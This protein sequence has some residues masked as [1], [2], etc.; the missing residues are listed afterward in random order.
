LALLGAD[1]PSDFVLRGLVTVGTIQVRRL[2][3]LA[4]VEKFAFFHTIGFWLAG[5]PAT[6]TLSE[7]A[8]NPQPNKNYCT[9]ARV[10]GQL[11]RGVVS[12]LP[13]LAGL[14]VNFCVGEVD[15]VRCRRAGKSARSA[16]AAMSVGTYGED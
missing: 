12:S 13:C 1:Q 6:G 2:L 9:F 4:L 14:G 15:L 16:R 3:F 11:N 5:F 7:I 8:L 10:H